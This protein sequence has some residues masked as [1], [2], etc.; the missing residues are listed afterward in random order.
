MTSKHQMTEGH[1][2]PKTIA[3]LATGRIAP[4]LSPAVGFLILKYLELAPSVNIIAYK[5]GWRGVL[6]GE[7]VFITA[8]DRQAAEDVLYQAGCPIGLSRARLTNIEHLLNRGLIRGSED[9]FE[10]AAAQLA[11]D[12]VDV[13]HVIGSSHAQHTSFRLS[14]IV[15][16]KHNRVMRVL[17]LPKTIE[18]DMYPIC[19]TLGAKTAAQSGA[20]YFENV[21]PEN[22]SNPRMLIIHE[23]KGRAAGWLTA[24][25]ATEYR[26]RL[27]LRKFADTMGLAREQVD[28]HA[29]YVP[30][31]TIDFDAEITRLRRVMD[32][33]D[34]VNIFLAQGSYSDVI[35]DELKKSGALHH[36]AVLG[37]RLTDA[38]SWFAAKLKTGIGAEKVLIQRSGIY[39]RASPCL[40]EDR[41]LIQ[42]MVDIAVQSSLYTDLCG[43]VGHDETHD[44][45]LRVID[46]PCLKGAKKFD[47]SVPWFVELLAAIGQPQPYRSTKGV[48][49]IAQLAAFQYQQQYQRHQTPSK[50]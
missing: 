42:S 34:N 19:T 7:R 47:V 12:E 39:V 48:R 29:V 20:S 8:K 25:T 27:L 28:I 38:A 30:E 50:L 24:A 23:I 11:K 44:G 49:E 22:N 36:H 21:V 16:A 40:E 15:Q 31:M 9:P 14:Q 32:R 13:L 33:N 43:C 4:C 10:K 26:R 5:F 35:A 3:V 46:I 6:V 41:A 37:Y 45:R 2:Q 17:G 18:N 1:M